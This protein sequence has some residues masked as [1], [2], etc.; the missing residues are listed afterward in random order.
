MFETTNQMS[1]SPPHS[2]SQY[3]FLNQVLMFHKLAAMFPCSN[4]SCSYHHFEVFNHVFIYFL[5]LRGSLVW[6][7]FPLVGGFNPSEKYYSVT[8]DYYCQY[9]E[10]KKCLKP[11]TSPLTFPFSI[12]FQPA[13]LLLSSHLS[14]PQGIRA[15]ACCSRAMS[16]P[17]CRDMLRRPQWRC[18]LNKKWCYNGYNIYIYIC[19]E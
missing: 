11:P 6:T 12:C 2:L 19:V 5:N 17:W 4:V 15:V 10:N 9:M 13:F 3:T 14:T 1:V 7:I 8:W 16:R 18:F